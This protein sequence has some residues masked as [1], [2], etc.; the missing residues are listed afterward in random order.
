MTRSSKQDAMALLKQAMEAIAQ[1]D[2]PP[3][4]DED[5][6]AIDEESLR[7]WARTEAARMKRARSR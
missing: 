4:N 6:D 2:S 3:A 5:D 1:S 7:E